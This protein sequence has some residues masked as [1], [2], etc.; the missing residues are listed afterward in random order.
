MNIRQSES[1]LEFQNTFVLKIGVT[2]PL[3]RSKI[4]GLFAQLIYYD[5]KFSV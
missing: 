4:Q 1:L 5:S 2:V 3:L